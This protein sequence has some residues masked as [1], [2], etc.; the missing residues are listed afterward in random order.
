MKGGKMV[1]PQDRKLEIIERAR[2]DNTRYHGRDNEI[3][4]GLS[5]LLSPTWNPPSRPEE[6]DLYRQEWDLCERARKY[7]RKT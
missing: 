6:R 7:G 1:N 4:G 3:L 2:R 5:E